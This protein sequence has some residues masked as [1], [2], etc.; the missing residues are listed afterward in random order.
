MWGGGGGLTAGDDAAHKSRSVAMATRQEAN[1][2]PPSIMNVA[3][4]TKNS[5]ATHSHI[6]VL[7]PLI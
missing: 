1:A 2:S 5:P 6:Y 4:S 7:V 3:V